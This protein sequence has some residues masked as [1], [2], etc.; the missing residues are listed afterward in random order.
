MPS[1]CA[2]LRFVTAAFASY[3]KMY[4]DTYHAIGYVIE[5]KWIHNRSSKKITTCCLKSWVKHLFVPT[6]VMQAKAKMT[7]APNTEQNLYLTIQ[8]PFCFHTYFIT[9]PYLN[10][11]TFLAI[12]LWVSEGIIA[13]MWLHFHHDSNSNMCWPWRVCAHLSKKSTWL[14]WNHFMGGISPVSSPQ[15]R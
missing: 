7:L 6:Y 14:F 2:L 3:K 5:H 10:T 4:M 15:C 9:V 8:V 11:D 12:F 1:C 13:V